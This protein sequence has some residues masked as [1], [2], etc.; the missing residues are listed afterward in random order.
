VSAGGAVTASEL[1]LVAIIT[2]ESGAALV[3]ADVI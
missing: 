2:E 3:A 1:A